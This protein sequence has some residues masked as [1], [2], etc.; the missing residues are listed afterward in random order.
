MALVSGS[1]VADGNFSTFTLDDT[2]MEAILASH[3]GFTSSSDWDKVVIS[4]EYPSNDQRL[5]YT[6]R[7]RGVGGDF[8]QW[9]EIHPDYSTGSWSVQSSYVTRWTGE[10]LFLDSTSFSAS[11]DINIT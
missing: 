9:R 6:F 5:Q 1:F 3:P 2:R 8:I 4:Y 10:V 7:P 11:D